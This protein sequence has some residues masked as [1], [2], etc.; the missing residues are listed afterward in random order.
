MIFC[1]M[2]FFFVQVLY[3]E[4]RLP[5]NGEPVK[6][7]SRLASARGRSPVRST[8]KETLEKLE[9]LHPLPSIVLEWRR[10]SSALSKSLFALQ[11]SVRYHN[12]EYNNNNY[13]L[14]DPFFYKIH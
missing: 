8:S 9:H 7:N 12:N 14:I 13:Y 3:I 4:L 5:V 10:L 2:T 6:A 11:K 1:F